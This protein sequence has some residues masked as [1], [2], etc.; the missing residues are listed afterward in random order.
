M[1]TMK[2]G[3]RRAPPLTEMTPATRSPARWRAIAAPNARAPD[4]DDNDDDDN[5]D[6]DDDDDDVRAARRGAPPRPPLAAPTRGPQNEE[7]IS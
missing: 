4:D 1:K 3:V 6:D 2:L 7:P 5:D